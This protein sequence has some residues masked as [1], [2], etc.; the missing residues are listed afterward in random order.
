MLRTRLYMGEFEWKGLR[1]PGIHPPLVPRAAW[2]RVQDILS[3]R[4]RPRRRRRRQELLFSGIVYCG[5][6]ATDGR[7]FQLVGEV[8]KERY[9][10]YHCEGCRRRG[11]AE[12]VR[13]EVL[14]R[15]FLE[16]LAGEGPSAS[17]V[18]AATNVL[19]GRER[20]RGEDDDPDDA[21]RYEIRNLRSRLDLAYDDRLTGRID[22]TYFDQ[23]SA[24]W[25]TRIRAL[26]TD[27]AG[28]ESSSSVTQR[29]P[30]GKP[31][32]FELVEVHRLMKES[33]DLV[34]LRAAIR[35][36]CSNSI[37]GEKKLNVSWS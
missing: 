9:V 36:L 7:R 32:I 31:P 35:E 24:G 16:A 17:A 22:S 10:Y 20:D 12:Y 25:L 5:R 21:L 29:V 6:C 15:A 19:T 23:R 13:Q 34:V 2:D 37:W 4:A 1:Y 3:G 26:E 14:V 30:G 8:Q 28:R 11:R 18:A 33:T 27:L